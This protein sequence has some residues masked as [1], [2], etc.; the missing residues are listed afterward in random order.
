MVALVLGASQAPGHWV[1]SG[2]RQW[3]MLGALLI[4]KAFI[5]CLEMGNLG[6]RRSEKQKPQAL[7]RKQRELEL[8]R[9]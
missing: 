7:L 3:K 5:V 1:H 8:D 9:G 2:I 6:E 4:A